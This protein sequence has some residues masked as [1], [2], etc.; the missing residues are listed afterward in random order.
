MQP[1][2]VNVREAEV[3]PNPNPNPNPNHPGKVREAES[4]AAHAAE[5]H[6]AG[7]AREA[8]VGR[9]TQ[10]RAVTMSFMLVLALTCT[11]KSASSPT[12]VP[13]LPL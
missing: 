5:L 7:A 9:L 11:P 4:T 1:H 2:P 10:V 8:E 12:M 6:Q 13:A 3:N